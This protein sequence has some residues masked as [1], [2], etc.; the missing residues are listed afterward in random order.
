MTDALF[1][2]GHN[3][4]STQTVL[5]S[6]V[7]DR[8]AGPTPPRLVVV[9]PRQTQAARR[10][11]VHLR[12]GPGT[13][14]PLLNGLLRLIIERGWIDTDFIRDHT[15]DF[16]TL[17]TATD[18]WTPERVGGAS[19]ASARRA[20]RSGGRDPRHHADA[21]LDVPP[22]RLPVAPGDGHAPSR[23]TTST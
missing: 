21:G 13:N 2:V 12:R 5:W 20:A 14:L 22:G 6:R 4:A 11:D 17:V 19:P 7:L 18:P 1:L 3:M 8:L 9:D 15:V 23:S 10:A 16:E